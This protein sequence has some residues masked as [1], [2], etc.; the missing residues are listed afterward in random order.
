MQY[1]CS[2]Y[3]KAVDNML[4]DESV[5]AFITDPPYNC[6]VGVERDKFCKYDM[7]KCAEV[8]GRALKSTGTAFIFCAHQQ[9]V[10]W[11]VALQEA[12]MWV[13]RSVQIFV[14]ANKARKFARSPQTRVS[15]FGVWNVQFVLL[16]LVY[17]RKMA[18]TL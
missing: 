8:I 18:S 5:D 17:F 1:I 2:D 13:E 10:D 7:Q 9:A 16:T 4:E 12:G 14:Y 3:R 15:T 6:L 11:R